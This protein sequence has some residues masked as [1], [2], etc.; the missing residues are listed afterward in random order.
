[1]SP[2]VL[3]NGV[4]YAGTGEKRTLVALDART[5]AKLWESAPAGEQVSGHL[6]PQS[7]A[8]ALFV[9]P[10]ERGTVQ[11]GERGEAL[12]LRWPE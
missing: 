3:A 5:G 2:P 11:P 7:R 1:M 12:L 4:A 8:H 9:V 6:T 10:A